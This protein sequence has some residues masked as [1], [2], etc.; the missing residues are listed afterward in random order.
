MTY[1]PND[2]IT[3][4]FGACLPAVGRGFDAYIGSLV[5]S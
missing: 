2:P 4:T 1:S 5:I 3:F